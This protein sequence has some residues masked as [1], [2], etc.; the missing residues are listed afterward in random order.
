MSAIT[1]LTVI[2]SISVDVLRLFMF[3]MRLLGATTDAELAYR[4][5]IAEACVSATSNRTERY[6]CMKI[7]RFE[8]LYRIDVGRCEVKGKAGELTAWQ[9]L[10]RGTKDTERLCKSTIEDAKVAIE[11]I[12][13]SRAACKHLPPEEQLAIFTRG[14]CDS[15]EGR[16]LSRTR[17]PYER[18]VKP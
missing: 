18:E 13:E 9:I 17:W 3:S 4:V 11:R 16:A 15:E 12:R 14:S 7:P 2:L 1:A 10:P 6:L 8:S 5:E